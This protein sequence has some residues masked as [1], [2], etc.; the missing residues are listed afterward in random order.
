MGRTDGL[1]KKNRKV[2][3]GRYGLQD[4]AVKCPFLA[5]VAFDL[6]VVCARDT[7]AHEGVINFLPIQLLVLVFFSFNESSSWLIA[8]QY[9][10]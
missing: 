7:I 1:E 3:H 9:L 5:D 10:A 8:I 6:R 2:R 4:S